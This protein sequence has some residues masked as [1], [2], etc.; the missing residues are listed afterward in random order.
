MRRKLYSHKLSWLERFSRVEDNPS[1]GIVVAV[2]TEDGTAQLTS[3]G[4]AVLVDAVHVDPVGKIYLDD[5]VLRD[6][7][8]PI[9]G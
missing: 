2:G 5:R 8:S 6:I 3:Y 4:E 1:V 7:L 9:R